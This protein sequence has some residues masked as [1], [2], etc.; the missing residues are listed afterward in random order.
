[1]NGTQRGSA[2][3]L[4]DLRGILLARQLVQPHCAVDNSNFS[5]TGLTVC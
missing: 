1:M 5:P 4:P 3:L 2:V